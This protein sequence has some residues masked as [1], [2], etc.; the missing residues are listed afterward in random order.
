VDIAL[1]EPEIPGNT[2]SIGRVAVGTGCRLHLVGKLGFDISAAAVRRAGLD[3]WEDVQLQRH[4]TVEGFFE[5][6]E[7]RR[8]WAYSSH[9]KLRY[10]TIGYQSDDVLVFGSESAGLRPEVRARLQDRLCYLP[11]SPQIRSLNLANCVTAVV[12]EALRQQGFA[13]VDQ[14]PILNP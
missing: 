9:G 7:G 1:I 2:G 12:Y 4:P 6:M 13:G 8:L 11:I 5:A 14:R 10:D 3:Y